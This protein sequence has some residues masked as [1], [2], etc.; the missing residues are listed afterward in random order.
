[1]NWTNEQ[2]SAI[3]E[4]NGKLLVAAGAGSGKTA[5]LVQRI[6]NKIIEDKIEIDQMLIVTFTNSAASEMR[7]RIRDGLYKALEEH[8]ELQNQILL[9]NKA[10]IMTIDAFCKKVISDHFF[11]LGLDPNYRVADSTENELIK[12]EA[13]DEVLEEIYDE[14]DE[15]KIEVLD[16]YSGS[17]SDEGVKNII[18]SIDSFIQSSPFPEE[19]L[20]EKCEMYHQAEDDFAKTIWGKEIILYARRELRGILEE[21]EAL[22]DSLM[23]NN[24]AKNYL[25]TLQ[26]DIVIL[27]TLLQNME[28]WNDFYEYLSKLKLPSLK[29]A[30]KL[31]E[32]TKNEVKEV[33]EKMKDL[34]ASTYEMKCLFL[35]PKKSF[36]VCKKLMV[37]LKCFQI[38]F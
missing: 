9:I 4:R 37:C 21:E 7:E 8:P 32:E 23:D 10:S 14:N 29:Q 20:K 17:K 33:R 5:V 34:V 22:A 12:L 19:W 1:M 24:E 6:M 18:L 38:S 3:D 27:K 13:L 35:L 15:K 30:P 11:K 28:T 2:K 25:L 16:A 26:D 31:D 36:K